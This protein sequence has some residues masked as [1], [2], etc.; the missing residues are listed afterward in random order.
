M[1]DEDQTVILRAEKCAGGLG[2]RFD[3]HV[4]FLSAEMCLLE[5]GE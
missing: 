2:D 4:G 5:P 1:I 3:A